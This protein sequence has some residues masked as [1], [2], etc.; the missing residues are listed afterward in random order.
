[1]QFTAIK[2]HKA[3]YFSSVFLFSVPMS[4]VLNPLSFVLC[5]LSSSPFRTEDKGQRTE[6]GGQKTEDKGQRRATR[7]PTRRTSGKRP[8]LP[9][10]LQPTIGNWQHWKLATLAHWQHSPRP[11]A[12]PPPSACDLSDP[13]LSPRTLTAVFS[14]LR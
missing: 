12:H 6:T 13:A 4:E 7:T 3:K 14:E 11:H 9:A 5:P 10:P 1:M 8:L 2:R